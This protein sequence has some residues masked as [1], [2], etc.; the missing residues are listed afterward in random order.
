MVLFFYINS[1]A[2]GYE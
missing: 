2:L 1:S